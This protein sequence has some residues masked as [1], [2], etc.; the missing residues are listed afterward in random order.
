[1]DKYIK[2]TQISIIGGANFDRKN[3]IIAYQIGQL[4]AR[5]DFILVNGGLG[6][7]MEA[8]ARGAKSENGLTVGILPVYDK[9]KANKYIDVVIPTGVGHSRNVQVASAG[10]VIIAVGGSLGTLSEI[11]IALKLDRPVITLHSWD[12]PELGAIK[13]ENPREAMDMA[14]SFISKI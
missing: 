14:L 5:N 13:V 4:I 11:C 9:N 6:G 10:E 3:E 1:M 12:I 2:K 8:S 7:V